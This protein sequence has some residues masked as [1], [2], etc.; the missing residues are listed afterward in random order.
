LTAEVSRSN[1]FISE[2]SSAAPRPVR[3]QAW[4]PCPWANLWQAL[5]HTSS[6]A[7]LTYH[8]FPAR[9][10]SLWMRACVEGYE[11]VGV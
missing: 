5:E 11:A 4:G 9:R 8:E 2:L 6:S 7:V 10:W 3:P 1:R